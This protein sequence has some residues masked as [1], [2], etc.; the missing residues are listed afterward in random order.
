MD[1][2]SFQPLVKYGLKN[3]IFMKLVSVQQ[4]LVSIFYNGFYPR[5]TENIKIS[6]KKLTY[7]PLRER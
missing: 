6:D 4:L 5:R 3:T 2:I 7:A 1:G